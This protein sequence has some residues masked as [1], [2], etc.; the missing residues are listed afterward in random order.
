MVK[1]KNP[2][3]VDYYAQ[4]IETYKVGAIREITLNKYYVTLKFLE[5]NFPKLL[6]SDLDRLSYQRILNLY[7]ETHE[8]QTT[9]DFHHHVKSCIQDAF[10]NGE[11]ERDPTY[12][13]IVKGKEP[14]EKKIKYLSKE[15]L[16]KLTAELELTDELNNDWL[17]LLIAKTGLRFAEALAI[18]PDDF[19]FKNGRLTIDKTW[20]YKSASG[21][22]APTKNTASVR[23]ILIDWQIR[24][25][26]DRML[27]NLPVSEPIFVEKLDNGKY[28]RF[29]NSTLNNRMAVLCKRAGVPVIT[30][31]GLRHTHASMLLVDEISIQM[32]AQRLGHATTTTTQ[33]TYLHIIK[34][35]EQKDE[36]KM[37]S[38]LSSIA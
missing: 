13:A 37:M 12:K 30:V 19:D 5:T 33:E 3:F 17:I 36:Q 35:L 20:D 28:K 27:T 29:F 11:L 16:M 22:F 26:F 38:A 8:K 18:T 32:I 2:L 7:A 15:D 10:H 9:M 25:Q 6:M 1:K 4:W 31:H 23:D 14:R 34:E 24:A 21:K